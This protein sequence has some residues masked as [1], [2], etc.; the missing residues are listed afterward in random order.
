MIATITDT[1]T[2]GLR[3]GEWIVI[4]G[5]IAIILLAIVIG[6]IVYIKPPPVEFVNV[7]TPL[8][9]QGE[10]V[11]RRESCF[12][13]HEV[14]GNGASYGP[15]LD[16]VGSRRTNEWLH[17]YLR[18]PR[19]GVSAK[20]YRLKMPPYAHLE[21]AELDGLVAYLKGLQKAEMVK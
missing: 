15:S 10:A 3:L 19:A 13:C 2:V 11:F 20:P 9:I 18:A 1:N 4:A 14:F 7:Q 21:S 6:R 8:G 16:G 5:S 17:E 12:S